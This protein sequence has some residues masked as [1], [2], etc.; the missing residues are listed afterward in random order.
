M[1]HVTI[2]AAFHDYYDLEY[3]LLPRTVAPVVQLVTSKL[4]DVGT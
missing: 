3:S 4:S 1:V 2:T